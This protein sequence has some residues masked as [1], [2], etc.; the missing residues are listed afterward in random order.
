MFLPSRMQPVPSSLKAIIMSSVIWVLARSVKIT[1]GPCAAC[2]S[3]CTIGYSVSLPLFA[4]RQ[5][6]PNRIATMRTMMMLSMWLLINSLAVDIKM[7]P[8][9]NIFIPASSLVQIGHC[10]TITI[11][12]Y[13]YVE[14]PLQIG[15]LNIH[16]ISIYERSCI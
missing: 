7:S 12:I 16:I 15:I 1:P 13:K 4:Q 5:N 2:E 11:I 9:K 8:F 6:T 3:C 14:L 10:V